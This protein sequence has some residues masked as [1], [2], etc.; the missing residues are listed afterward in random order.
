MGRRGDEG[1][2]RSGGGARS[3]GGDE[4]GI[5][6]GCLAIEVEVGIGGMAGA[7][8]RGFCHCQV[9]GECLQ[10]LDYVTSTLCFRAHALPM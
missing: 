6:V 10:P 5:E 9:S 2:A 1:G 8:G 4:S 7:P 3:W